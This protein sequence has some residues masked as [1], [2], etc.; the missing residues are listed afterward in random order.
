VEAQ[1]AVAYQM[2]GSAASYAA[3]AHWH[4]I[5]VRTRRQPSTRLSGQI[6]QDIWLPD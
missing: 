1:H 5:A 6:A 3:P 4:S 2:T